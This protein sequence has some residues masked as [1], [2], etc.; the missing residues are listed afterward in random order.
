MPFPVGAADQCRAVVCIGGSGAIES[1]D[2]RYQLATGDMVL[3]PAEVGEC[4][5]VPSGEIT[6][7]ECGLPS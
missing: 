6:V 1:R 2:R 4:V 7:L 3:L 5:C